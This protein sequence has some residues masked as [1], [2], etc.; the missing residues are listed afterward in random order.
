[1][2]IAMNNIVS[3]T[4]DAITEFLNYI[5]IP[6]GEVFVLGASSSEILGAKIGKGSNAE[7][8][9][10]IIKEILPIF[11]MRGLFLAV[12][13][14]EHINR[15]LV[16]EKTATLRFD[17]E[18]VSVIPKGHAGGSFAT[19]AYK[20]YE[21]PVMVEKINAFSGID[22]GNTFIGM[23]VRYVQVPYR[24]SIEKIGKAN[25]NYLYSRPK[26]IGGERAEYK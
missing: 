20:F 24:G 21:E 18:I 25:I 16:I 5:R 12:Q 22:I 3:D 1:M 4:K 19:A 14:C 13:G 17:Y 9:E 23:H 11:N 8:G 10:A 15:A 26:L 7:I 6:R 2:D